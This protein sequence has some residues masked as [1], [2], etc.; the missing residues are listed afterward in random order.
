MYL[1]LGSGPN[2]GDGVL[3]WA[4]L[5]LFFRL[6]VCLCVCVCVL[7]FF[8]L[9][10]VANRHS[11]DADWSQIGNLETLWDVRSTSLSKCFF[12]AKY[13]IKV[14]AYQVGPF[15]LTLTQINSEMNCITKNKFPESQKLDMTRHAE[16]SRVKSQQHVYFCIL[17]LWFILWYKKSVRKYF[18]YSETK[19]YSVECL[20][21]Y[22]NAT[23]WWFDHNKTW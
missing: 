4:R 3:K 14:F 10:G 19:S 11:W 5:L 2:A 8:F 18:F 23:D 22:C 17:C 1:L 16:E 7:C 20:Y 12:S 15:H 9:V 21:Y 13:E 6:F